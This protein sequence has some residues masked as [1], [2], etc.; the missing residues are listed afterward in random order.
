M[1]QISSNRASYQHIPNIH[2]GQAKKSLALSPSE[3]ETVRAIQHMLDNALKANN[4]SFA[5]I[6]LSNAY[7]SI[8]NLNANRSHK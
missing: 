6:N 5:D 7:K 2:I 4:P 1:A 3:R 8:R